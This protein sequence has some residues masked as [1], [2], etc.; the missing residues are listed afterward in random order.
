MSKILTEN[1]NN[2][3]ESIIDN[4]YRN[5]ASDQLLKQ[6]EEI[7]VL[8]PEA[9]DRHLKK[10]K[11]YKTKQGNMPYDGC[12]TTEGRNTIRNLIRNRIFSN[13]GF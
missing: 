4:T 1:T 10:S 12:A 8:H 13:L 3:I 7:I 6:F 2:N 5:I 9:V 11:V